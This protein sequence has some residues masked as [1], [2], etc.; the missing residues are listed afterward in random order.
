MAE[1]CARKVM[2]HVI[3]MFPTTAATLVHN[4]LRKNTSVTHE[5]RPVR[6]YDDPPLGCKCACKKKSYGVQLS[7][8]GKTMLHAYTPKTGARGQ[9][10]T[11]QIGDFTGNYVASREKARVKLDK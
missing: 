2:H 10:N 7:R 4:I 8:L 3:F 9:I 5:I 11:S 6:A 1:Q